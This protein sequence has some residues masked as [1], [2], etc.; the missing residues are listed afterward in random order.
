ME[1]TK[2]LYAYRILR[3]GIKVCLQLEAASRFTSI[4][5]QNFLNETALI[6]FKGC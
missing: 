6:I 3:F 2:F 1:I 4:M 5:T